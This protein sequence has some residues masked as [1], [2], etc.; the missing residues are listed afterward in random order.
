[1]HFENV[2]K[3]IADKR[4]IKKGAIR[5]PFCW[6]GYGLVVGDVDGDVDA[7]GFGVV[8]REALGETVILVLLFALP[9]AAVIASAL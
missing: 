3:R 4:A 9:T 2:R 1:M 6:I 7:P 8:V 5:R